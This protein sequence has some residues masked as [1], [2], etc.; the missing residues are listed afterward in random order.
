VEDYPRTVLEFEQR[1]A[2]E[3]ACRDYL[4][5]LRWPDGYSCPRCGCRQTWMM[6]RDLYWCQQCNYQVSVTAGTI[7]QDRRKPLRLW[8]RAIW[9]VVNQKNGVSALGLQRVLGIGSYRTAWAWLHKL[10]CA[11]V[12]P[13]R[14]R[15]SGIVEV[16]ET[17]IGGQKP[18]KRGR[19][20]AR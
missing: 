7:F 10:R 17:Y 5:K 11:M 3:Q 9:Y 2:T 18:G 8:F 16:D 12:R 1:F 13:G 20:A 14:E 4:A 19:G 6:K 15:L